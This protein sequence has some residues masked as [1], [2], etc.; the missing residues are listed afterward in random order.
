MSKTAIPFTKAAKD[1][2]G[3]KTSK[4]SL[5][6]GSLRCQRHPGSKRCTNG[7]MK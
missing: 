5:S 7:S 1:K 4:K 6:H 2:N 3:N